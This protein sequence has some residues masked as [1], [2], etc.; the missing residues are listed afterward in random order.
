MTDV[1]RLLD[2][3]EEYREAKL[4]PQ[5]EFDLQPVRTPAEIADEYAAVLR[6]VLGA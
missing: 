1:E 4:L 2:L 3:A 5:Y 6:A